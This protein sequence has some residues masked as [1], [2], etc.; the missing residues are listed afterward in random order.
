MGAGAA[1]F[2]LL[3]NPCA[4]S[5]QQVRQAL[6]VHSRSVVQQECLIHFRASPVLR[7]LLCGPGFADVGFIL[8]SFVLLLRYSNVRKHVFIYGIEAIQ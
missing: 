5:R 7:A 4:Q 2:V 6:R 8:G 3:G 1:A